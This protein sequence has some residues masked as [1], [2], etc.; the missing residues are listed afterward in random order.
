MDTLLII[1]LLGGTGSMLFWGISDFLAKKTVDKIGDVA[2][3]FWMQFLGLFPLLLLFVF[4]LEFSDFT[5]TVIFYTFVLAVV[6]GAGYIFF[7][8][9]LEKGKVSII[10]PIIA[11]YGA[12][13]ILVS[14][15]FLKEQIAFNT[16]VLL[17]IT[18]LGILLTSLNFKQLKKDLADTKAISKGIPHALFAVLLFSFYM[19]FWDNVVSAGQSWIG[20]LLILRIFIALFVFVFAKLKSIKITTKNIS[21]K[22]W[23]VAMAVLD[24]LAYTALT[25][26][27]S[28]STYTSIVSMISAALP[29]PT[30][31]LA[32]I[33]LKEKLEK[34]Q[35]LGVT[36][37]IGSLILIPVFQ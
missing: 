17:L 16:L 6:D 13:A 36:L 7:F 8:K 28:E 21:V 12:G 18:F 25:W 14:F 19:P 35:W 3:V 29:V 37:I 22:K 1:A 34:T 2:A 10:S 30:L 9:A 27:Y 4:N 33:F 11:S 32:H 31:I 26:G 24:V 5:P 20:L 15:V 23:L